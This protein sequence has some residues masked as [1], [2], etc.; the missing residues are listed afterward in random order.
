M[1]TDGDLS[2]LKN[3]PDFKKS[4]LQA[5]AADLLKASSMITIITNGLG[6]EQ[7]VPGLFDAV[8]SAWQGLLTGQDPTK[9]MKDLDT[10]WDKKQAAGG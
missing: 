2:A 4:P 6:D 9:T 8:V 1:A 7:A 5:T 10:Y 3:P